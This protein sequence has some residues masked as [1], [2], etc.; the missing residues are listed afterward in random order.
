MPPQVDAAIYLVADSDPV[1]DCL[2]TLGYRYVDQTGTRDFVEVL[3][4]ADRSAEA[5]ALVGVF[6]RLIRDLEAIDAHN[7]AIDDPTDPASRF[8]HIFLYEATEALALQD[9]VKRHLD[10][11]RVRNGLGMAILSTSQGILTDR[12]AR[13]SRTGGEL[14]A[15]VW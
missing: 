13:Q 14:L 15:L 6:G 11:P 10:D 9:A 12:Q 8:A 5:D 1:D 2:V 3:P 7:A 4:T